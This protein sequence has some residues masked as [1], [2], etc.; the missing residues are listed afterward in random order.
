MPELVAGGP[1]IPVRLLNELDSGQVVFFCGAGVS[2]GPGSDLPS[3]ADLV[4]HVYEANGLTPDSVESEALDLEEPDPDR[5]RPN[6]D[7][8]LGLLERESRLGA[9][10]LRR[11]VI[12]RLSAPP[13]GELHLHKVL[14]DLSRNERGIRLI[15]TDFDDRF[16]QAGRQT[17]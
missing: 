16:V 17:H 10:A 8:A 4:R 9:S 7:K 3:F 13:S 2:M 1:A 5:R 12:K 14:I 6:F 15:T 11:A